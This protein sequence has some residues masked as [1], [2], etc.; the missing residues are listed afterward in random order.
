MGWFSKDKDGKATGADAMLLRDA[1]SSLLEFIEGELPRSDAKRVQDLRER[2]V[3][4]PMPTGLDRQSAS[5]LKALRGTAV[6]A[7]SADFSDAARALVDA[8]QRVTIHD[9]ELTTAI[10]SL[11]ESVPL[12]MRNGDARLLEVNA[13]EIQKSAQGAR[14]RQTQANEA[15][16]TLL[17]TLETNLGKALETTSDL[18][19]QLA[20][21]RVAVEGMGEG[22]VLETQKE[23]VLVSLGR[24]SDANLISRS[25]VDQGVARVRELSHHIRSQSGEVGAS[26]VRVTIDA[27][28][29]VAD[30]IAFLEALPLALV[31]A[32]NAGGMLTCMR[33]NVDEMQRINADYHESSGD[34]VL[35]TVANTIVQQLRTEDFVARI[36]GDDFAALLPNTGNREATGAAKR[37]GRKVSKMIF[38][39]QQHT[40]Q[41]SISLGIATWDGKESAESLYARTDAALARAKKNGGAQYWASQTHQLG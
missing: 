4:F 7:G 15:V 30:R 18:E 23:A 9:A 34:D 1:L 29:Q 22:N 8:M 41:V 2:L 25:R 3:S 35:R 20:Q 27:L 11:G 13:Q 37:L 39:H 14:F 26:S 16:F 36:A 40:F 24:I 10:R 6:G 5:V 17:N 19:D 32:R 12:R 33:I 31:E 38:T 28:T 21:L